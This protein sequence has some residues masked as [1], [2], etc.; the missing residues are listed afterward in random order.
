MK[1]L[2]GIAA[3]IFNVP[4]MI[5]RNKLDVILHVLG[6]R[7]NL[8]QAPDL[9]ALIVEADKKE[10]APYQVTNDGIAVIDVSDTLVRKASG[11]D[12]LSGLTS[13][14]Q[15]QAEFVEALSD[16]A[17]KGVL[18]CFDTPG[19]EVGGLFDLVDKIY[20]LKASK[21]LYASVSE[22]AASAGYALASAC[23]KVILTRTACVG[24]IGVYALHVDE[25]GFDQK[26]GLKYSYIFAGAK[27]VD[28][29]PHQPLSADARKEFQAEIDRTYGLFVDAVSRNR[30]MS[31]KKVRGT[32]AGIYYG[33]DAV[34]QGLADQVGTPD[35][36][37]AALRAAAS[38]RTISGP[39]ASFEPPLLEAG[40]PAIAPHKTATT[41]AS[42]D[43]PANEKRLNKNAEESYYRKEYAWQDPDGDPET[44][45][46]YKFP[47]HEVSESG[48]IGAANVKACDSIIGILNGGMGGANIPASDRDGVYRHAAKHIRDSGGEPAELKS[49]AQLGAELAL[50]QFPRADAS[51]ITNS[52]K[53]IPMTA[54]NAEQQALELAAKKKAEEEEQ[55]KKD[56]EAKDKAAE[57]KC[58]GKA[59][60]KDDEDDDEV[61]P[62]DE[63]DAKKAKARINLIKELCELAGHKELAIDFVAGDMTLKQIRAK[64]VDLRVA[65]SEKNPIS[66]HV[67]NGKTRTLQALESEAVSFAKQNGVTK[68]Q[69]YVKA[70]E[71]NPDLY[72]QY[73]REKLAELRQLELSGG[74]I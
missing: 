21:P 17:I 25:S 62:G 65:E 35:D 39:R 18:A 28:G 56:K 32:E 49:E 10:R 58:K 4:L 67:S 43:G 68:E 38:K 48:D 5:E 20:S 74:S 23:D 29:N 66:S 61:K 37:M 6:P 1:T 50:A 41:D 9:S 14:E 53:E 46:A 31:A 71:A 44:K 60:D 27:K 13:Y 52:N 55:M 30:K 51:A 47:H 15:I 73:R 19:G 54:P 3:R 63:K 42:W 59:G 72:A 45:A 12:A 33:S 16:P 70:L 69:A 8:L 40:M 26:Q 22:M 34:A 36:A 2:S 11:M 57:E 64:L 24:S 7:M